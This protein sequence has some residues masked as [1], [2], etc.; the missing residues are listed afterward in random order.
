MSGKSVQKTR[1]TQWL[2]RRGGKWDLASFTVTTNN[3][4]GTVETVEEIYELAEPG[5]NS[6]LQP[7]ATST[8]VWKG[9]AIVEGQGWLCTSCVWLGDRIVEVW[10]VEPIQQGTSSCKRRLTD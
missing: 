10:R 9:S 3:D 4:D 7:G 8:Y 5:E 6:T 1:S 2:G